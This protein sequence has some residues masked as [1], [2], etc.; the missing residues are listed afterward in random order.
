MPGT[1]TVS[2]DSGVSSPWRRGRALAPLQPDPDQGVVVG[3][4][5]V[6]EAEVAVQDR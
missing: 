6:D 5:L 2:T 3:V 4:S 1:S